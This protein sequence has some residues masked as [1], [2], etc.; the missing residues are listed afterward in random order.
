MRLR[1]VRVAAVPSQHDNGHVLKRELRT[2]RSIFSERSIRI[3]NVCA[4]IRSDS[5]KHVT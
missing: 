2:I 5:V 1:V 4:C 3:Q